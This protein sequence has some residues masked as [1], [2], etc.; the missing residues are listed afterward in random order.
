MLRPFFWLL[1]LVA[2]A[3]LGVRWFLS[4]DFAR[5][6]AR[7][8]LEARLGEAIARP[9]ELGGLDFR[10]LP[11]EVIATD[12]RIPGDRPD[13]ADF[14]RVRR[15]EIGGR[16]DGFARRKLVL[17]RVAVD[18]L[19]LAVEMREDGD[20]LPRFGRGGEGGE[21]QVTIGSLEVTDSAVTIDERRVDVEVRAEA[22]AARLAGVGGT[23]LEG[24]VA[25]QQVRLRLP[26]SETVPFTVAG[27]ARLRSDRVELSNVR[28]AAPEASARVSGRIGWK[29]GTTVDLTAAI[30]ADGSLLDRFGWLDGEI[31]GRARAEGIFGWRQ[32]SW[33]FRA[34]VS[35]PGLDLFGF[36]LDEIAGE[37]TGDPE[38][39]RFELAQGR[40]EAGRASGSFVLGLG[41]DRPARLELDLTAADLD[42]VLA[43]FDVPVTGLAGAVSGP[44][45]YEF[46][47]ARAG[48]G[49][50]E[51]SFTI[52]PVERPGAEPA[53]GTARVALADGVATLPAF[54]LSLPGQSVAGSARF[55][56]ARAE[57][58]VDLEISSDDL[59]VLGNLTPLLPAG[60]IWRPVAGRGEISARLET[61]RGGV[62]ADLELALEDVE[63]PGV[64]AERVKGALTVTGRGVED[65]RLLLERGGA[66]LALTGDV[67]F[68]ERVPGLELELLAEGWPVE[69]ARPWLP[70][71]LPLAGPLVGHLALNG[72][73]AA[74]AGRLEG[75]VEPAGLAGIELARLDAAIE[76]DPTAAR[77]SK[78]RL[79]APAGV[80]TGSGSIGLADGQLDLAV[81]STGLDLALPPL[82]PAGALGLGGSV[83]FAGRVAGTLES[84]AGEVE[85]G[86]E[87]LTLRGEPT[88]EGPA[89]FDARWAGGRLEARAELPGLLS[90]E[91]GGELDLATESS[92]DFELASTRLDRLIA[93]VS[94]TPVEGLEG[95]I[96]G[97]V[98]LAIDP[99]AAIAAKL[100]VPTLEF[101]LGERSIR[102]LEPVAARVDGGGVTIE[103]LYLGREGSEDELFVS[104][105]A[106]FG[107]AGALD[108]NVEASL[109]AEWLAP[110]AAGIDLGGRVDAL[111][112]VRG[113]PSRPEVNG[114]AGWTGGRYLPPAFPHGFEQ[115]TALALF[116]PDAVVLDRLSARFAGGDLTAAGRFD[117]P[118]PER[119]FDFRVEAAVREATVRWPAGWQLR[120]DAD[121]SFAGGADSRQVRGEVRLDRVWY[122][123]DLNLTAAQLVQRLLSRS[124]VE[125]AET[126]ELLSTTALAV[127]LRAPDAVRVRNNL[128]RL[129]GTA[130]LALRGTLARPVLF[131][132]V[133]IDAGGTVEYGGNV[134]QIERGELAFVNPAR[135]D[136]L[137]DVV[138]RTRIDPYDVT[139]N[140]S[141]TLERL[142]TGFSADPPLPDLD[143]L[144]LLAT[145]AP[146]EGPSFSEAAAS[147][148]GPASSAGAE[149]LLYGQAASLLTERVGRLFGF[150]QVRVRPLT[151]GDT[152]SAA[153]VTV[154]K[155][156]S[157]R[158]YVTY[159]IDP[160][161]DEQQILQVEWR[162]SDSL[163]LVL[164][165]NGNDSYAVDARWEARF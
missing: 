109:A 49:K 144:G 114:Q 103:S 132:E 39:V 54:E 53:L 57:G 148:A 104:G 142:S 146:V 94:P 99:Q 158:I 80:V 59:G 92:L 65:M 11:L 21:L 159:T 47:L 140:L 2:L 143:V 162:M 112:K 161:S 69:D 110:F 35:S 124:R 81:A 75:R 88:A 45:V 15:L 52:E 18:G 115:A 120:G 28:V 58:R 1:A 9:V 163:K 62:R 78:I 74:L 131:G 126:D 63:A 136:P 123:Q 34:D 164:T 127:V 128:A 12:L 51:G 117:L 48:N 23:D 70:F 19:E 101:R 91:G 29:G 46:P 32:G 41:R 154:G 40:F 14:A 82:D 96:V 71:E 86:I 64:A 17:E 135:I 6:R 60:A 107:E 102:S 68:D 129:S 156:L 151:T 83:V 85:G 106:S 116:Y 36:R 90:L 33:S 43:R 108:L 149:A 79:E 121:L 165:Q 66:R 8:L 30:D 150:D 26:D 56:L 89:R 139:V 87:A 20:N 97:S 130:E 125:V 10:L 67:P 77:V 98:E 145:G 13:A 27:K 105:R 3:V 118:T 4:S 155:R 137:L 61:A 16:L 157:R 133:S 5:E 50:G 24:T 147:A 55:E 42:R 138:A 25:A 141:G 84:P 44:F 100:V 7:V 122:T 111:A 37:A 73:L 31:A 113:T 38:A 76:F 119:P 72:S 152:V 160:S 134:Y 93:L 22:V 95:S 153:S